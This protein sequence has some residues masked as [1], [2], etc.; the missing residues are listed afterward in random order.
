MRVGVGVGGGNG[1]GIGEEWSQGK[2][3]T[4]LAAILGLMED[5]IPNP[6]LDL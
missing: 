3:G 1:E 4:G 2:A 5:L 6:N